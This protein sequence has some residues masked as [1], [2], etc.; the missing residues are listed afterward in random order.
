VLI[1]A[2]ALLVV[3]RRP[4]DLGLNPDGDASQGRQAGGAAHL[5][6]GRI[7][8][9]GEAMR[10]SSFWTITVPFAMSLFVQVGFFVHQIPFLQ[11]LLNPAD[12]AWV[13]SITTAAAIIGR[14]VTGPIADKL[15]PRLLACFVMAIQA[16]AIGALAFG[17]SMTT[18][19]ITC[20]AFG[21][22]VGNIV[23][24]PALIVLR[25]FGLR[26][27]G[28]VVSS[29]NAITHATFALGPLTVGF[30]HDRWGG[31]GVAWQTFA[32]IDAVALFMTLFG[33]Y[34]AGDNLTQRRQ[35]SA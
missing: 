6:T 24:L 14:L 22:V 27:F 33:L 4:E 11:T 1:S 28:T 25:E 13:V 10:T 21:A 34:L 23:T 26:S 29:V 35:H 32:A 15:N 30:I 3:K 17:Q 8:T 18:L 19:A 16:V 31:Y 20:F 7:W 5:A 12:A 9:R 2:L